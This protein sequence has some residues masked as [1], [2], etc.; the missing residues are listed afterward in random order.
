MELFGERFMADSFESRHNDRT[1][2]WKMRQKKKEGEGFF[3]QKKVVKKASFVKEI[4]FV[5]KI[6]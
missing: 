4:A 2:V 3:W 6:K 5:W 1:K